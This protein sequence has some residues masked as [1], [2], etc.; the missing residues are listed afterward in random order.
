[1]IITVVWDVTV[2]QQLALARVERVPVEINSVKQ[3]YY[4]N[5]KAIA[6]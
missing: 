6:M 5:P 3:S 2:H 4:Q 1:M